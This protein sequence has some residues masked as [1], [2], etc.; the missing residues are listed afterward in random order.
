VT[1]K[2][3]LRFLTVNSD[4][5]ICIRQEAD[6]QAVRQAPGAG[7]DDDESVTTDTIELDLIK[8]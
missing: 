2:L 8:T 4:E 5:S 6:R 1:S 7:A 3:D